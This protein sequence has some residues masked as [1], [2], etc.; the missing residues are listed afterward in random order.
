MSETIEQQIAELRQPQSFDS[1]R[2]DQLNEAVFQMSFLKPVRA[3]EF[4]EQVLEL[5]IKNDYWRGSGY[6]LKNIGW[7]DLNKDDCRRAEEAFGKSQ[8]IFAVAHD[9]AGTATVFNALA[10]VKRKTGD[11]KTALEYC[12]KALNLYE[13]KTDQAGSAG[14]LLN[15]GIVHNQIGDYA[16]ALD[17]YYQVLPLAMEAGAEKVAA[18]ARACLGDVLWRV[19]EAQ[20][21]IKSSQQAI[22]LF[23]KHPDQRNICVALVNLGAAYQHQ[24]NYQKALEYYWKSLEN[25][26]EIGNF[27]TQTEVHKCLGSV[28]LENA[29]LSPAISH[30]QQ[31][32]NLTRQIKNI[33]FESETLLKLGQ[34]HRKLGNQTLSIECLQ[35]AIKTSEESN[36]D[37]IN[38]QAHLALSEIYQEQQPTIALAHYQTFHKIWSK[39]YNRA[40]WSKIQ[41]HL[42]KQQLTK[43]LSDGTASLLNHRSIQ[44]SVNAFAETRTNGNLLPPRKLQEVVK[45]IQHHLERNLTVAKLAEVVG[46][47]QNYFLLLFKKTTGKTPHQ[48]LIEQRI[49][50]AQQLLRTTNLP[51]SEIALRCGFSSQSHFNTHFRLITGVTPNQFRRQS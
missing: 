33:Y 47:S 7:C 11:F 21:A 34:T 42:F 6:A 41:Q 18:R 26:V 24:R 29:Q 40:S 8:E 36:F 48:F 1:K 43:N 4:G 46:L 12:S 9:E 27:E 2:I 25:A 44:P 22:S 32:L 20:L 10:T 17:Y 13:K 16:L 14:V 5:T 51:L 19:E 39:L 28:Y 31:A 15:I 23:E 45:F 37:E 3:R 35:Q 38:Y 30:L 50:R 49:I